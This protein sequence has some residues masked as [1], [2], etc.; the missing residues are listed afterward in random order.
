[1]LRERG[2]ERECGGCVRNAKSLTWYSV[3]QWISHTKT[4]FEKDFFSCFSFT[5][6]WFY[7]FFIWVCT[8]YYVPFHTVHITKCSILR[9]E[10]SRIERNREETDW[11]ETNESKL[12]WKLFFFNDWLNFW[13]IFFVGSPLCCTETFR[14][15]TYI[16]KSVGIYGAMKL[17]SR[18]SSDQFSLQNGKSSRFPFF[19]SS[20]SLSKF[21]G[22]YRSNMDDCSNQ[23]ILLISCMN[24]T[25]FFSLSMNFVRRHQRGLL[26]THRN[27][28]KSKHFFFTLIE[29]YLIENEIANGNRNGSGID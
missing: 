10:K 3:T 18:W 29:F 27:L 2:R 21:R 24:W 13:D 28:K 12:L 1:M 15:T 17:N 19:L 25:V 14:S 4:L 6:S 23:S 8:L 22:Y 26:F 20:Y 16:Y 7:F 9:K 11:N 5:H